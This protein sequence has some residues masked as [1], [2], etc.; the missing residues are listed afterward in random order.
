[1]NYNELQKVCFQLEKY[2][3]VDEIGN[4]AKWL[5]KLNKKQINNFLSLDIKDFGSLDN[6]KKFLVNSNFLMCDDYLNK[7]NI[8]CNVKSDE[9]LKILIDLMQDDTFLNSPYYHSDFEII[10]NSNDNVASYLSE[11]ARSSKSICGKYHMYDMKLINNCSNKN[12]IILESLV[13][14]SKDVDALESKYHTYDMRAISVC[15]SLYMAQII[16]EL[17]SSKKF[18][19][20][21]YHEEDIEMILKSRQSIANYLKDVCLCNKSLENK[22]E[23][24]E[25]M[26]LI[27]KSNDDIGYYLKYVATNKVSLNSNFHREHMSFMKDAN[28]VNAEYIFLLLSRESF[29]KNESHIFDLTLLAKIKDGNIASN[30]FEAI[31]NKN[32]AES[33]YRNEVLKIIAITKNDLLRNYIML[34][35]NLN[36]NK[37][38]EYFKLLKTATTNEELDD[39]KA[40]YIKDKNIPSNKEALNIIIERAVEYK[41]L[42][43]LPNH[44]YG[45]KTRK[46]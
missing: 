37:F 2:N 1:M 23:H 36:T 13:S 16:L 39:I 14:L 6:Y 20:F 21:D 42:D 34:G 19:E 41:D 44:V 31:I 18:L 3:L 33:E 11:V 26:K 22:E 25:D 17:S 46:K 4:I 43:E 27:F 32:L 38:D 12:K 7:I 8:L 30:L 40:R 10:L 28:S 29:M 24:L 35:L 15:K 5:R 45:L 9:K